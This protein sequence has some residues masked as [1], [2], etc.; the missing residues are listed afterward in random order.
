M[1]AR[2]NFCGEV[3]TPAETETIG[4]IIKYK[5]VCPYCHNIFEVLEEDPNDIKGED[6]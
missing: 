4:K 1:N 6:E 5:Y 3:L 2:C